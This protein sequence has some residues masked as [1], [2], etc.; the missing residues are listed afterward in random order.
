MGLFDIFFKRK[1][2]KDDFRNKFFILEVQY[3]YDYKNIPLIKLIC[4]KVLKRE[5]DGTEYIEESRYGKNVRYF[6]Y[7][8]TEEYKDYFLM[9]ANA[10]KPIQFKE[11]DFCI[12]KI[13]EGDN[14][15]IDAYIK[16]CIVT[17]KLSAAESMM[18]A[19]RIV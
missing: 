2:T 4:T 17:N 1:K 18:T 7:P 14:N 5:Y 8:A 3:S 9:F 12:K 13:D 16:K 10:H 19:L 6:F 15:R 11:S